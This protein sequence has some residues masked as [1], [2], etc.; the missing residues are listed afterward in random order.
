MRIYRS[1]AMLALPYPG[2]RSTKSSRL[3]FLDTFS[4]NLIKQ[5]SSTHP[6]LERKQEPLLIASFT[7]MK[8]ADMRGSELGILSGNDVCLSNAVQLSE[9]AIQESENAEAEAG[10]ISLGDGKFCCTRGFSEI[11]RVAIPDS[12]VS[13]SR[14]GSIVNFTSALRWK[15]WHSRR[16]I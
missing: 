6:S 15:S 10:V 16:Y 9:T 4:T 8:A 1:A 7:A 5:K 14:S 13:K 3:S 11:R 12:R 2:A